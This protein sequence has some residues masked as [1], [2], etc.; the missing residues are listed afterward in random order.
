[1]SPGVGW[2]HMCW[3]MLFTLD[4]CKTQVWAPW[5]VLSGREMRYWA[6]VLPK[7]DKHWEEGSGMG[8]S[9]L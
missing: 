2:V 7:G 9:H 8:R 6:G 1:M 4:V 5:N 3:P